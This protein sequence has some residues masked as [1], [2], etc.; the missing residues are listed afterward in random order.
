MGE[1]ISPALGLA[2]LMEWTG[3]SPAV[4]FCFASI[5][6]RSFKV[7]S[8]PSVPRSTLPGR[9]RSRGRPSLLGAGSPCRPFPYSRPLFKSESPCALAS[10][11]ATI[12][13][14]ER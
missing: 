1:R 6:V 9:F 11:D 10:C 4:A 2:D 3:F 14:C 5:A 7:G 8:R 12:I 13:V